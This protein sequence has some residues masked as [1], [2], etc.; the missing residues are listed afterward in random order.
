M[1]CVSCEKCKVWG[2]LQ[3]LGLGTAV[4]ILL[5]REMDLEG[6]KKFLN[7]QE[8]IALINTLNQLASSVDFASR[9]VDLELNEKIASFKS[10]VLIV[11][12]VIVMT[13]IAAYVH[14]GRSD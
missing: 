10:T 11:S 2:K 5:S 13:M 6:N 1:D 4:K 12:A 9:A 8:V 14:R 3:I 7:R